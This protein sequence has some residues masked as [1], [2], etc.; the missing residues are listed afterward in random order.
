MPDTIRCRKLRIV[1]SNGRL[2][3][4]K[5]RPHATGI[6]A[7]EDAAATIPTPLATDPLAMRGMLAATPSTAIQAYSSHVMVVMNNM[8]QKIQDKLELMNLQLQ[9]QREVMNQQYTTLNNNICQYG[10]TI[11][12]AFAH[13]ARQQLATNQQGPLEP[14]IYLELTEHMIVEPLFTQDQGTWFNCG[15]NGLQESTD[16]NQQTTLAQWNGSTECLV[17][18]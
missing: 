12:S 15:L 14:V 10:G 18:S 16:E 6:H 4:L 2:H 17:S 8:Q 9:Q 7:L 1:N 11:H 3:I 13:Q 5:I